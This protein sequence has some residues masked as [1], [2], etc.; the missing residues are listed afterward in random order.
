MQKIDTTNCNFEWVLIANAGLLKNA[1]VKVWIIWAICTFNCTKII[2]HPNK[3]SLVLCWLLVE[4]S[5]RSANPEERS[6]RLGPRKIVEPIPTLP[7]P[8]SSNVAD[9]NGEGRP[10]SSKQIYNCDSHPAPFEYGRVRIDL[11][12][13]K[14][15]RNYQEL[16]PNMP[17]GIENE[18][19]TT[20]WCLRILCW[21][22]GCIRQSSMPA[23]LGLRKD[24]SAV[25]NTWRL[26]TDMEA[27]AYKARHSWDIKPFSSLICSDAHDVE[28][29]AVFVN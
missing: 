27:V 22:L 23:W 9:T 18:G 11:A 4:R 5:T 3:I 21:S 6:K 2:V 15:R 26:N 24:A 28:S 16:G 12:W 19:V 7:P 14:Q 1:E 13:P 8:W 25:K 29:M 20:I 17:S 10:N